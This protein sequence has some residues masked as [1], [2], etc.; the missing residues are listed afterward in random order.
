MMPRN[1]AF[2]VMDARISTVVVA[3]PAGQSVP[4]ASRPTM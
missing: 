2:S 1:M 3:K 4:N